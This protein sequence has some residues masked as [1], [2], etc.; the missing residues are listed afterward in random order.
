MRTTF[1]ILIVL[2]CLSCGNK[3]AINKKLSGC[4][5]LVITFNAPNSDSIVSMVNTKEK[6][7]IGKLA[8]F[9]DGKESELYKCGYDG[10][11]VFYKGGQGVLAVAFK[12]SEDSCRHFVFDIDNKLT[13]TTMSNEAADFL[14]SLKEGRSWY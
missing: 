10:N 13:S 3:S 14:R 1:Y 4:D 7:A 12:F 2:F 9:L 11:M 5:S 8:G 6:K